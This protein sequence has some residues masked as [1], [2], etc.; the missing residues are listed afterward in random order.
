MAPGI[1]PTAFRGRGRRFYGA[2]C[3]RIRDEDPQEAPLLLSRRFHAHTGK[4][5]GV[6]S[7]GPQAEQSLP[8]TR[9]VSSTQ[10]TFWPFERPSI[11]I[12]RGQVERCEEDFADDEEL[13]ETSGEAVE[14]STRLFREL[15]ARERDLLRKMH[16]ADRLTV[17]YGGMDPHQREV[18][19]AAFQADPSESPVRILLA[20]DA[21]SEGIDVQNHCARLIHYEIPWNPNR[22]E[23]R[24]GRIDR[25]G[26]RGYVDDEGNRVKAVLVYHFVGEG[27]ARK[28]RAGAGLPPGTPG[29]LEGD[30]EFLYR[31]AC[32]IQTIREDL[33]KVGR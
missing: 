28:M 24:N 6:D 13:E 19:K 23:Q 32:K 27:Y 15:S 4:A 29:D 3:H 2:F 9:G 21:A 17:L 7:H 18:V 1:H 11:G 16:D 12:L 8:V 14:V 30:I 10:G 25:H 26:Q 20:T 5:P 22:L 33:G 31:A